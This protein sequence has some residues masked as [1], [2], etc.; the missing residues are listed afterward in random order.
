MLWPFPGVSPLVF[1]SLLAGFTALA[2]AVFA[3]RNRDEPGA[4]SFCV[5]MLGATVWSLSYAVALV[6][7]DPVVR[8][9]FELPIE[10]G[11]ALIAPA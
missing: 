6:T 3:F 10:I 9:T 11:Q 7:F 4:P 5:F 8:Q 1:L 2:L